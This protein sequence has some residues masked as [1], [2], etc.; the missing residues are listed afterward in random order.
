MLKLL[1]ANEKMQ[2][3][4]E[5]NLATLRDSNIKSSPPDSSG[6][7]EVLRYH[8]V[9]LSY[10]TAKYRKASHYREVSGTGGALAEGGPPGRRCQ[11]SIGAASENRGP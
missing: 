8:A 11:F 3:Q 6:S 1:E 4:L 10:R 5:D 7:Q 9:R 2:Q